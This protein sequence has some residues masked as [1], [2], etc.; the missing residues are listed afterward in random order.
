MSRLTDLRRRLRETG[1]RRRKLR[2]LAVLLAPYRWRVLAM[3]VSLVAATVGPW[4]S[5]GRLVI[6]P[7]PTPSGG[8]SPNPENSSN[9]PGGPY[10]RRSPDGTRALVW[11]Q[12]Q[13]YS[14][15]LMTYQRNLGWSVPLDDAGNPG[16]PKAA[17]PFATLP[18][19][20]PW[21]GFIQP[22]RLVGTWSRTGFAA[23]GNDEPSG[24]TAPVS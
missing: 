1:G 24:T 12:F 3:F 15:D 6:P 23:A 5:L 8:P 22:G 20:C 19:Y 9:N 14:N 4:T 18:D 11:S 21:F 10:V 17:P 16:A 2:R 7:F 13:Q